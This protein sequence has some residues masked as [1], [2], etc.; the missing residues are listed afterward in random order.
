MQTCA[1]STME[2]RAHCGLRIGYINWGEPMG[3]HSVLRAF[4]RVPYMFNIR[5]DTCTDG[6]TH[7]QEVTDRWHGMLYLRHLP[8]HS[9]ALRKLTLNV[10]GD[11]FHTACSVLSLGLHWGL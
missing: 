10:G 9:L 2:Y 5:S 6:S 8:A 1:P 11:S 7:A 4:P 3:S